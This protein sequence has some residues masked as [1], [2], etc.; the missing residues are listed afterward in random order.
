MARWIFPLVLLAP[1]PL[2]AAEGP[3]PE[4]GKQALLG[5]A[6]NLA[7]WSPGAY[8]EAWRQWGGAR[9]RPPEAYGLAFRERYGLHPAPY[10]N[11]KLPMG[12][13]EGSGLFGK[14]L[15]TDCLLCHGGSILGQSYVGLGNASLDAESLFKDLALAS[16][17]P[18]KL[19]FTFTQVRGTTEASTMAV[20]LL[21]RREPDLTFRLKARDFPLHDEQCEDPPAW[22]LIRKKKTIYHTGTTDARSVR[23]IMQFMLASTHGPSAFERDEAAFTDIRAYLGSLEAPKY[24]FA[25]D[26]ELAARGAAIFTDHCAR[27]HGTYGPEWSYPNKVVPIDVIGTDRK[28]YEGIAEEVGAFYNESWFARETGDGYKV[29]PPAGYQAPPLDGIWATAP[30]LHNGSVPTLDDMLNSKA[31]PRIFTRS[32]RT[33]AEA[34]DAVKVGWKVQVLEAGADPNLPAHEQ[35]KVYDTRRPGRGNTGHTFG[36][37]LTDDQRRAVI[38]YLK[39]L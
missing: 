35:R 15:T 11:G 9:Q 25:I 20:Y 30:Y 29:V 39:T 3:S 31:R 33:D 14:G 8:D 12:L 23:A 27:C 32:Y 7:P 26:G 16:G 34:F 24:P 21:A 22:W 38:E 10:D 13:R 18:A 17:L 5:R 28:R 1:G 4:R 6:Y 37:A 2:W 36:D 19:P